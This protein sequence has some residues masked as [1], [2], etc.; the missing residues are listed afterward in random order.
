MSA[1]PVR[2]GLTRVA[3]NIAFIAGSNLF[4]RLLNLV[5]HAALGR[6]FG[7]EGLGGY[8]TAVALAAYFIFMVD[9][10]VSPRIVREGA[11]DPDRLEAEYA[12]AMGIKLVLG[13]VSILAIG[14]LGLVLPYEPWVVRLCLLL[15]ASAI[16]R[17]FSY[18]NQSVCRAKERLDLEGAGNIL[19]AVVFVSASLTFLQLDLPLESVGWASILAAAIQL[20]ATQLFAARF[21]R[22]GV[23]FPPRF[24][25]VRLA[26]PYATT[27]LSLL[28]F[29]QID[30]LILS[31]VETTEFV[32]RYSAISRL[33]LIAGT[34]GSLSTAAILPTAA[35]LFSQSHSTRFDEISNGAIRVVFIVG[36]AAAVATVFVAR[37]LISG[38]YGEAFVD[39]HPF[40]ES[41]AIYL[42]FKFLVSILAMILTSSGRQ[43]D[44]ARSVL[45]GLGA[46]VLLVP[47][48][49]QLYGLGGAVGA[50]V[51]S[52]AILV[53]CLLAYLHERL[54]WR[55]LIRTVLAVA[56]AAAA[57]LLAWD[58]LRADT[59]LAGTFIS[60]TV[61]GIT[62][63]FGLL[64]TGEGLRALRFV[65]GLRGRP[66]ST[67]GAP[68]D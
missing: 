2:T 36:A 3:M 37:P 66:S 20:A 4:G 5:L 65:L 11:V 34:L 61:P 63:L 1:P 21:V 51:L 29:A 9:F 18:L 12:E 41:G 10:G 52:E 45:V 40:L 64:V 47:I 38:I 58:V 7:P 60:L 19:N 59:T 43:G 50:L 55:A 67:D 32:G 23:A 6:L 44:R 39:L 17:S 49:A 24:A 56:A 26:L 22:I 57:S 42:V 16:L 25:I 33:L 31:F 48:L 15:S 68:R 54:H 8:A 53:T 14:G 30:V 62:F 27:S 13:V 35:R 28:A 46:T